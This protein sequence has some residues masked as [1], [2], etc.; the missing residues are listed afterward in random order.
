MTTYQDLLCKYA[1]PGATIIDNWWSSESG[2]PISGISMEPHTGKDRN[3]PVRDYKPLPIKPGSAGKAMPGFDVRVV[4]DEGNE[5]KQGKMGNV[6]LAMPLAPTGFRTLWQE[7]ERFYK[8]YLKR[9]D[10]RWIDTGDAGVIDADGYISIMSRSDD[11]INT[12]GHR[13]S[14]GAIEQ[15][16]TGHPLVA[17]ASVVGIPDALKGQLPFAFVTL[18]TPDHPVSAV[19]DERLVTEIQER[20]RGQIGGIATLGGVC[21]G[22]G[23]IPKTRSGKTLRRVLRELLENAVHG[24]YDKPVAWPATIEDAAVIDVARAKVAEYFKAKGGAHR[25]VEACAKL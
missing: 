13:L 5:V 17:E 2:S 8:S 15:A 7:E 10:G 23:M 6:V 1:A 14:T 25:A 22:R 11:L 21:Q 4:D 12:A 3:S 9:F 16:I 18:S 20:V 24:D 19:P